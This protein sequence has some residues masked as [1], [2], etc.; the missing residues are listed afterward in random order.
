MPHQ[1]MLVPIPLAA[2]LTPVGPLLL[3]HC[4]DV[5]VQ[6]RPTDEG[7][8]ALVAIPLLHPVGLVL[9]GMKLQTVSEDH[10]VTDPTRDLVPGFAPFVS[11]HYVSLELQFCFGASLAERTGK[12]PLASFVRFGDMFIK[13]TLSSV[14]ARAEVAGSARWP[15][16]R[17]AIHRL[18]HPY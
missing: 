8:S 14:S 9:H 16:H 5:P 3:M 10:S 7:L 18:T 13:T 6:T 15:I 1:F 11:G 4:L 2:S 17:Q 12:R